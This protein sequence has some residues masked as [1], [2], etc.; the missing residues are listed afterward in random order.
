MPTHSLKLFWIFR[1]V[2]ADEFGKNRLFMETLMLQF[3]THSDTSL[4]DLSCP[5]CNLGLVA[6]NVRKVPL[7]THSKTAYICVEMPLWVNGHDISLCVHMVQLVVSWV[8]ITDYW[9]LCAV[10]LSS[11][12][13][14]CRVHFHFVSTSETW[15][16]IWNANVTN[17]YSASEPLYSSN[18]S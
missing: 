4:I 6:Q 12:K 13:G 14:C 3:C 1:W 2:S 9:R 16:I 7:M 18:L 11:H 17:T 8:E 15:D 5:S 10:S